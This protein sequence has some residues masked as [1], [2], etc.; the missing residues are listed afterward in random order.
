MTPSTASAS[1]PASTG[2]AR[3]RASASQSANAICGETS[4][5]A[6]PS[7]KRLESRAP[8]RQRQLAQVFVAFDQKV[9]GTQM[10]RKLSEELRRDR[11]AVE[12]LLQ[13]VERLN[14]ALAHDQQLAVD[15]AIEP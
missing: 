8:F 4:M 9:V 3:A 13:N 12:P 6:S 15:R 14:A 10:R 5:R 11:F 2:L 7:H 1:A